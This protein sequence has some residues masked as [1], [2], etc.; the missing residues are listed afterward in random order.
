MRLVVYPAVDAR[1]RAAIGR[2]FAGEV[3]NARSLA[4]AR[5]AMGAADAFFG[6]LTPDLL[7][8]S[9]HLRW[10][11]APTGGLERYLFPELV[12]HPCTLTN[13]R[14]VYADPVADQVMA[15]VL[16][17]SRNLHHYIRAAQR[18]RWTPVGGEAARPAASVGPARSTAMDRA[19]LDLRQ[20][21]ILIVGYGR[22]GQAI[23]SRARAFGCQVQGVDPRRPD[24]G[25]PTRP[26]EQLSA[27]LSSADIVVLS[28]P[29][30]E[31]TERLIGDQELRAMRRSA[32][33][34]NVARGNL[35]DVDAL[36]AALQ[37]KRIAGAALDVFPIE[38]LPADH[39]LWTFPN[40]ILTPHTAGY[41]PGVAERHLAVVV[42]NAR[43]FSDGEPLLNVV[44]KVAGF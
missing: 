21:N 22:I 17:F 38:P 18:H 20:L 14:G 9:R 41:G 13:M 44:D 11:Q 2:A 31:R 23:A 5:Q 25:T 39:P 27:A 29:L 24:D 40:V 10:V 16:A 1:R 33:L 35:V 37:E 32:Y 43:R 30:T 42:E 12:Q 3:V 26:P 28:A 15:Y 7:A 8:A 34:I 36:V 4:E 6:S 19:A